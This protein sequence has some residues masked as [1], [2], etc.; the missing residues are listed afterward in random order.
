ME[1]NDNKKACKTRKEKLYIHIFTYPASNAVSLFL[2]FKLL[3][4]TINIS[5]GKQ[6][7]GYRQFLI[8]APIYEAVVI[9]EA[10]EK[11]QR[12]RRSWI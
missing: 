2:I 12:I 9:Q 5:M 4:P 10:F 6:S 11:R 7:G 1:A 3:N 8:T